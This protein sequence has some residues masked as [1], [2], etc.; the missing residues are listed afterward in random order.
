MERE[1]NRIILLNRPGPL[2]RKISAGFRTIS[3]MV[4]LL[5][6]KALKT[7]VRFSIL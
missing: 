1:K 3:S 7:A 5:V 6:R 2:V 4:F